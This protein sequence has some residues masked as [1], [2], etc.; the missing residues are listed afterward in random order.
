MGNRF[1]SNEGRER[2]HSS[3]PS[4]DYGRHSSNTGWSPFSR[5]DDEAYFGSGRMSYGQGFSQGS[6]GS[7]DDEYG[8]FPGSEDRHYYGEDRFADSR[9][10]YRRPGYD[11]PTNRS[12][13]RRYQG[14]DRAPA[15]FRDDRQPP[16]SYGSTGPDYSDYPTSEYGYR[17]D[18]Y[19]ANERG[20]WDKTSDEVASWFGDEDAARR[21]E[22]DENR[23]G[24]YR[25]RGPKG[26]TRS[27]ERIKEDINDRLTD[28][29]YVDASDIDVEVNGREVVLT[30]T[31]GTRYEKRLAEDIAEGVSGVSNVENRIRVQNTSFTTGTGTISSQDSTDDPASLR[32]KSA[33]SR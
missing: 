9:S 24:N 1:R 23:E 4:E 29:S 32:S 10:S 3:R 14:Y 13:S 33:S 17:T 11:R 5:D 22:F 31:V 21:R 12:Y 8:H 6:Y 27:D 16:Y 25:G 30:G 28:F 7:R 19:D 18:R 2:F 15:R 26:Y 20:W